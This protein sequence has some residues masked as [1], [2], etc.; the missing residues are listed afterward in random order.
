LK[1]PTKQATTDRTLTPA[2]ISE[3]I[4]DA[5]NLL[6]GMRRHKRSHEDCPCLVDIWSGGEQR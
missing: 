6:E 2:E 4:N 5:I 3:T 1:Q